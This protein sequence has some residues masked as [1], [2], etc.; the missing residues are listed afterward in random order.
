MGATRFGTLLRHWRTLRGLSQLA[1]ATEAG[2]S[3]R[4]LSFLETG[5]AQPSREMVLLL[6]GMLGV[7][8]TDQN[9]F[10][11]CAG[12]AP[13]ASVEPV[14]LPQVED[15]SRALDFILSQQ[16]P[17]PALVVDAQS[18]ILSMN[19]GARQTFGLFYGP[20]A[21][22]GPLNASRTVFDPGGLRPYIANWDRLAR[23]ILRSI[24]HEAAATGNE[25][26][27]ELRDELL[28]YPGVPARWRTL[29]P[30]PPGPM[31]ASFHLKKGDM[32]LAFL[33]T[34]TSLIGA[35]DAT[36]PSIR[37]KYFFPAD[38]ATEQFARRLSAEPAHVA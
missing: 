31:L 28:A 27:I 34:M 38:A 2:I 16:E 30:L 20:G 11:V 15:V 6:A 36:I 22:C 24:V 35:Q 17:Y 37:I 32:S 4:H 10:L 12:Y 26:L 33:T 23:G 1:L 8:D 9:A 29:D 25:Q 13:R 19:R 7:P 3:T 18:N 14:P 21:G 5:R